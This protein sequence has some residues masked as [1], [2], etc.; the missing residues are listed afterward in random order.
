M[1]AER[2][3]HDAPRN[4]TP[5]AETLEA[6]GSRAGDPRPAG[7]TPPPA[8]TD[9]QTA[10]LR[11]HFD[12]AFYLAQNR[13]IADAGM[14]PFAHYIAFGEAEGRAPRADF[15]PARY[16]A[17]HGAA[18]AGA[19]SLF[20][21]F[22]TGGHPDSLVPE[23]AEVAL[24]RQH[25]DVGH[26]LRASP[27]VAAQDL[28]PVAHYLE[29]GEAEGRSPHP[30]FDPVFYRA[31]NADLAGAGYNLFWHY[32]SSGRAEGR[33]GAEIPLELDPLIDEA[34]LVA[35]L[36]AYMDGDAYLAMYPDVGAAG[37]DP[38]VHYVRHGE[39]EGRRPTA[40]FDPIL[41]R[42][43][44]PALRRAPFNLYWYALARTLNGIH[45]PVT[46]SPATAARGVEVAR[47]RA[48]A[49]FAAEAPI[50]AP[51]FDADFYLETYPHVAETGMEPLRHYLTV[52]E[53]EGLRPCPTFNPEFYR[54]SNRDVAGLNRSPFWH[55]HMHGQAELRTPDS[56]A[57]L[58]ADPAF[59]VSA[60]VPNYNH[61]RFLE[62][63]L[64]SIAEQTYPH[65]EI[66]ILD[67]ASTD[68]SLAV[69]ERF[70]ATTAH[71]VRVVRNGANAG[72]VFA[73][74]QKG[75][76][77]ATGDLVWICESDDFCDPD[78][79]EALVPHFRDE[80]VT[81]AF[82]RIEFA[83]ADGAFMPGME[84]FRRSAEALDWTVPVKRPAAAWFAGAFGVRN[85][86]ANVG[87][88]MFRRQ[89]LAD[90]VWARAQ[91]F[92]IA[93]D[94]YLYS[95]IAGGGQIVYEP[96]ARAHFRQHGTNTSASNFSRVFYYR[97]YAQIMLALCEMWPL[98][99]ATRQSFLEKVRA[100]YD[101]FG[102]GTRPG[103]EDLVFEEVLSVEAI[104]AQPRTRTHVQLGFLG[105]HSGGGE[106]FAIRLAALLAERGF[107]VTML[108]QNL[109]E[110]QPEMRAML[111]PG[112]AVYDVADMAM[113]GRDAF[114]AHTGIDLVHTHIDAIDSSF[115]SIDPSLQVVPYVMTLHGSHD[116]LDRN[117][118]KVRAYIAALARNAS[119]IVYTA[120]KNLSIFPPETLPRDSLFKI[121]NAMVR[122]TAPFERTRAELGIAEDAVVFTF[123][124]RGIE[125]KGWRVAVTAFR[126]L[127][128][129]H[130]DRAMHLLLVGD[131]EKTEVAR[132]LA[133]ELAPDPDPAR[134]AAPDRGEEAEAPGDL[135]AENGIT[136][137]GYQSRVNGIYALSD[138]A[139][140]PTRYPGES[141]P[142][143]LI[144]AAQEGVPIIA[145]RI[146]EI[147]GML[148]LEEGPGGSGG[149]G[150]VLVPV[151]RDTQA[152][153]ADFT[154]QMG[155]MLDPAVRADYRRLSARVADKFQSDAMLAAYLDVYAYAR[156]RHRAEVRRRQAAAE[157]ETPS[158]AEA[159]AR[160]AAAG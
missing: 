85:V 45:G 91:T 62:A 33:P 120:D 61:A 84:E 100:E 94:W 75:L 7:A 135:A 148:S 44:E 50:V 48:E 40:D 147:A 52:G 87:G 49:R 78:F 156:R 123:V 32:L 69:I 29:T 14:D 141:N 104:M 36:A 46:L 154:H 140:L 112:I 160:I 128:K 107:V 43:R 73:Q 81:L 22:L 82:G 115:F 124:A 23:P 108:A 159:V 111:P 57:A 99:E 28:D 101:H 68:D 114:L 71:P 35:R 129:A 47:L 6:E 130:P 125:R 25:F 18:V 96:A 136:F 55:Y 79:A 58:R 4:E 127:Q 119:A 10:L 143:C 38:I 66:I 24:V 30:N 139:I 118:P 150:G 64:A 102:M 97:E 117:Q 142:L 16:R 34:A 20:L 95:Q 15:D 93:G 83:D 56:Y 157:A 144:Q 145:S 155:R 54:R 26:Y 2:S 121:A 3:D 89:H 8:L 39:D 31:N 126:A 19:R 158:G 5:R 12:A 113:T 59:R 9:A 60:I 109:T 110:V 98:P 77:L 106:V 72:N 133:R 21:H 37:F 41:Y 42:A 105:F 53:F 103:E 74:W 153:A 88:A 90:A 27:E 51:H 63:R 86:I 151:Q 70:A 11:E 149:L 137:L 146:G 138:C 134:G 13:D 131:G 116:F 1:S 76:A 152:F 122:D 92:R 132:A 65:I 67:D 80:S 17:R